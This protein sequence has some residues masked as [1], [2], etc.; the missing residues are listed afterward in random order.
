M[1]LLGHNKDSEM[2]LFPRLFFSESFSLDTSDKTTSR[3]TSSCL[4]VSWRKVDDIFHLSLVIT[5]SKKQSYLMVC[6]ANVACNILW[7]WW[8]KFF[9]NIK[10]LSHYVSINFVKRAPFLFLQTS[11]FS[12]LVSLCLLSCWALYNLKYSVS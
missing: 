11:L 4:T 9:N 2:H 7:F 6:I 10:L 1:I 5:S 8:D 3:I 12:N